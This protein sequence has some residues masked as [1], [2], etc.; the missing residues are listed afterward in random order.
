[1][2]VQNFLSSKYVFNVANSV[3]TSIIEKETFSIF[4]MANQ[5]GPENTNKM[6][7]EFYTRYFKYFYI[8]SGQNDTSDHSFSSIFDVHVLVIYFQILIFCQI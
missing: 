1:M 6:F 3:F 7:Q 5:K 4:M 2:T 8:F